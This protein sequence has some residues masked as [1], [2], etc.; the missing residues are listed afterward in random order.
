MG[1]HVINHGTPQLSR[2]MTWHDDV[3]GMLPRE[4]P[5][6][7]FDIVLPYADGY[8]AGV[9]ATVE[10]ELVK[11]AYEVILEAGLPMGGGSSIGGGGSAGGGSGAV[12]QLN[13]RD[14]CT[15]L[16]RV[17]GAP[18]SGEPLSDGGRSRDAPRPRGTA[19]AS[20]LCCVPRKGA[21]S[22]GGAVSA[23]LTRASGPHSISRSALPCEI[24]PRYSRD[25]AEI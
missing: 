23:S 3:A 11:V 12:L 13:H 19:A 6:A 18:T 20:L 7:D 14:L 2:M 25:T 9:A 1:P 21:A 17:C 15:A 22:G 4:M 24:S 16:L 5:L 8:S 10:A